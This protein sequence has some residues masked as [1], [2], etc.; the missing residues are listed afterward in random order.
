[1]PHEADQTKVGTDRLII[2]KDGKR[3]YV[4]SLYPY[5]FFSS[6]AESNF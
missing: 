2:S 3:I 5:E 6:G 4:C 1:M